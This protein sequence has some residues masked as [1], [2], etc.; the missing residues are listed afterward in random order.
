MMRSLA[1]A[2]VLVCCI[3]VPALADPPPAKCIAVTMRMKLAASHLTSAFDDHRAARAEIDAARSIQDP[4]K[5]KAAVDKLILAISSTIEP[6]DEVMSI[7]ETDAGECFPDPQAA[8]A[9]AKTASDMAKRE[10]AYYEA[11]REAF[12]QK[13]EG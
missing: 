2:A 11:A 6:Y 13:I 1:F 7:Y 8:V 5:L 3:G 10:L 4:E 9:D 12:R